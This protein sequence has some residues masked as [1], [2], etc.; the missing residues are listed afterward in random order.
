MILEIIIEL[1]TIP[2][3]L[4]KLCCFEKDIIDFILAIL[5]AMSVVMFDRIIVYDT[6]I[7]IR[8]IIKTIWTKKIITEYVRGKVTEKQHYPSFYTFVSTGKTVIPTYFPATSYVKVN[9]NGSELWFDEN[10]EK[11][12]TLKEGDVVQLVMTKRLSKHGNVIDVEFE[13]D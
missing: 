9:Y 5:I 12:D 10:K 4:L 13:L 2:I 1:H 11:Y 3:E 6:I 7:L 8:K